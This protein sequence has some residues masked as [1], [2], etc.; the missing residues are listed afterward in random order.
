MA[1]RYLRALC[2]LCGLLAAT[3]CGS[4]LPDACPRGRPITAARALDGTTVEVSFACL[5]S[6]TGASDAA[7]YSINDYTQP[8]S[9][10]GTKA[11]PNSV[12]VKGVSVAGGKVRLHTAPLTALVT[13]TLTVSGVHDA[14][15]NAHAAST[16]FTGVGL[17]NT[18][19]VTFAVDDRYSEDLKQVWLLVS[20]DPLSGVFSHTTHRVAAVDADKDHVFTARLNVAR[21]PARTKDTKDDRLGANHMAYS[22]RAVDAQNRALSKLVLF[23]V[24]ATAPMTVKVPLLTVPDKPPVEGRVKVTFKVDDR[25]AKALSKPALKGSFGKDGKFDATFPTLL[26][27][28]DKDA[29]NIWEATVEVWID[30]RRTVSGSTSATKPYSVYLLESGTAYTSRS[31]DFVVPQEKAVTVSI[32][33]GNKD[34]VPVT[35]RVDVG[36]A[37]L[38]SDGTSKGVYAGEAVFLTGEFGGAEDAFGQNATDSF[39]GGENVVLQMVERAAN[40]GVWERTIFLPKSKNKGGRP[41][42]WKVL[43]CPK[44]KGCTQLNKMVTSSGRAFPTVMK[45]LVT[46]MCDAGKT[47]WTDKNCKSPRLIDPRKLTKVNTGAGVLNYSSAKVWPGTGGGL[48]DQQDPAGTP[49]AT[50]M[51]KQEITDLVVNVDDK[52]VETPVYVIGSWRDVNISG[53][54]SDIISGGKVIDLAKSDYDAGFTGVAPPSY[55]LAPAPKPSPFVMDGKLDGSATLVA[56]GTK[57]NGGMPLYVGLSGDHLYLATSD[58]GEG[59]D[60]FVLASA[61]KPGTL[62]ASPWGKAGKVAFGGKTLVLADEND[63]SY[64]GWFVLG[65]AGA[66]KD[67]EVEAMGSDKSPSLDVFAPVTNGGVAE[68]TINLKGIFGSVPKVIYLA[69]APWNNDNSGTLYQAAQTPKSKNGDGNIDATEILKLS[70]PGLKVLP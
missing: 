53:T 58:S 14:A 25:Q 70:L 30:P 65:G 36:S 40:K 45:N 4:D 50:L 17:V 60:N 52:P 33:V 61:T 41:Y 49:K 31:A 68:G 23:E 48:K 46:E 32:L 18:S 42:G 16:N 6:A 51:F 38:D 8:S 35:F 66:G 63:N 69:A 39:S 28:S 5:L 47:K 10:S 37:W 55:K 9:G 21:D 64:A 57:G 24:T 62:R 22:V 27:L 26:S 20:V 59:S 3:A 11:G 13:Y 19:A 34:K 7:N 44:D 1:P 2:V 67:L 54:P 43:R 29:D 15:G 56:G 12:A